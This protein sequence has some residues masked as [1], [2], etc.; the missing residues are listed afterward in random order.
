MYSLGMMS[1]TYSVL[2]RSRKQDPE[3]GEPL[4]LRSY[5]LGGAISQSIGLWGHT[6][7]AVLNEVRRVLIV[8]SKLVIN[9]AFPP[10]P[11][12]SRSYEK[13]CKGRCP[14]GDQ[15]H[16]NDTL[17]YKIAGLRLS[18]VP[19]GTIMS[20]LSGSAYADQLPVTST[21]DG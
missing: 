8:L 16:H 17:T 13:Q 2:A 5:A 3:P 1:T 20:M 4:G 14:Q 15:A 10:V 11:D 6:Y 18:P 21:P 9:G 7:R 19:N 12:Y